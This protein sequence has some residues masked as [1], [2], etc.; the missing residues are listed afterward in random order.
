M[1][2]GGVLRIQIDGSVDQSWVGVTV[3]DIAT[4]VVEG[5]EIGARRQES[6]GAFHKGGSI[7]E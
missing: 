4:S 1:L 5:S 2:N 3:I 7:C 6:R